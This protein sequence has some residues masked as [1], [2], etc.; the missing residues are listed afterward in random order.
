MKYL[1]VSLLLFAFGTFA[2]ED[3]RPELPNYMIISNEVDQSL[4][5]DESKFT[6]RITSN[7]PNNNVFLRYSID[8]TEY[9]EKLDENNAFSVKTKAGKH[10]FMFLL[11]TD[12]YE[13][14]IDSL[15][16]EEQHHMVVR[17]NFKSSTVPVMVRKPV[18]YL[19]P[20]KELTAN[21]SID[22][23]GELLF[24]YPTYKN[25]WK[26]QAQPNG[27]LTVD[28]KQFNYLFWDAQM[29]L[30]VDPTIN[31]AVIKKGDSQNYIEKVLTEYGLSSTE[32]ADFITYWVPEILQAKTDN[33]HIQFLFN[34]ECNGFADL[35]VTP[36]PDEIG[37]IYILWSPT[38]SGV[39]S[40]T[41]FKRLP[42]LKRKGFTVVEWGGAQIELPEA[43]SLND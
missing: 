42:S 28:G 1:F 18:I 21:I 20:Q 36:Q 12:F 5:K 41:S 8:G 23:K 10:S 17:L 15:E 32:Q 34:E 25:G 26:V 9:R 31:S 37:R 30:N 38:E 29:D 6:F 24:T 3:L 4:K 33:I 7:Q 14:I 2:A 35:T 16:I 11:T 39:R 40:N 13:I 27:E 22:T 19:Y 43:I